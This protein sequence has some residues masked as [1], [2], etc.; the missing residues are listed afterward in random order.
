M[1]VT[2]FNTCLMRKTYLIF[3]F[4]VYQI[5]QGQSQSYEVETNGDTLNLIDALGKKQGKWI[6]K[7]KHKPG[8]CF[9]PV[10]L[11]A[12]CNALPAISIFPLK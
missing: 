2:R 5:S 3:I 9:S 11:V 12:N 4:L 1:K 8:S 10:I 6:L 7:G